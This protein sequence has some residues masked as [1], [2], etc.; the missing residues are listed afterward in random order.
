MASTSI[1]CVL[2]ARVGGPNVHS[3]FLFL[4][5]TQCRRP[6]IFGHQYASRFKRRELQLL[7]CN[8]WNSLSNN[9]KLVTHV[10]FCTSHTPQQK[11]CIYSHSTPG[12][13]LLLIASSANIPTQHIR[14][15]TARYK[16]FTCRHHNAETVTKSA[17]QHYTKSA[18]QIWM[19]NE[20]PRYRTLMA[21]HP[22]TF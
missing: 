7:T 19:Q 12:P 22:R 9:N 15:F 8:A 14:T 13:R 5:W 4:F 16:R 11:H 2:I 3:I 18:A 6:L 21:G 20:W 10:I 1:L 17:A